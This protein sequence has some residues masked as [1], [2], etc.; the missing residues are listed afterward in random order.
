M[1]KRK[2]D[3]LAGKGSFLDKLRRRREKVEEGDLEGASEVFSQ[4]EKSAAEKENEK[5]ELDTYRKKHQTIKATKHLYGK[6]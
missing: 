1:P 2:V 6:E 3:D 5:D 4:A